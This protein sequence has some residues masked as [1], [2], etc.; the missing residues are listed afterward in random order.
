MS[1]RS[2]TPVQPEPDRRLPLRWAVILSVAAVAGIAA[3]AAGGPGAG[4]MAAAI[5]AGLL[6]AVL[7]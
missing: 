1:K 3:G 4:I 5:V 2:I 6:H 7:D